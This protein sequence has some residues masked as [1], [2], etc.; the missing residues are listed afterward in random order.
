[1][2]LQTTQRIQAKAVA[3]IPGTIMRSLWRSPG[4]PRA[5]RL[6][7]ARTL[8]ATSGSGEQSTSSLSKKQVNLRYQSRGTTRFKDQLPSSFPIASAR[9]RQ[10]RNA[11]RYR[12][13][14]N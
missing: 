6:V 5:S 10:I 2:D 4:T 1:M 3:S 12:A 13:L 14:H 11:Y 7:A 9:H 8:A